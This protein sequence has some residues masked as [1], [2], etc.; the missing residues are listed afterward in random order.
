[1][2]P[3]LESGQIRC[4]HRAS[5]L[6]V[7]FPP[8]CVKKNNLGWE[9]LL[10]ILS[11]CSVNAWLVAWMEGEWNSQNKYHLFRK[12]SLIDL[13]SSKGVWIGLKITRKVTFLSVLPQNKSRKNFYHNGHHLAQWV[14][15]VPHIQRLQAP[16]W[17]P[18]VALCC[19]LFPFSP[20]FL[21]L[22]SCSNKKDLENPSKIKRKH[23]S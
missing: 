7:K 2:R 8:R 3:V 6:P 19:M 9:E 21:S 16:V 23:V 22:S 17:I 1:M 5:S 4:N 13:Y 18:S 14:E 11:F 15:Q 20:H 12:G 10:C